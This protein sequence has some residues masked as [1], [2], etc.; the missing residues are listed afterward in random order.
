M[1]RVLRS[2]YFSV[3]SLYYHEASGVAARRI[4]DVLEQT[5]ETTLDANAARG[6]LRMAPQVSSTCFTGIKKLPPHHELHRDQGVCRVRPRA[7]APPRVDDPLEGLR[8][9][10]AVCVSRYDHCALALSGGL[11]SALVLALLLDL[12][13][14][15]LSVYTLATQLPG[16]CELKTTQAVADFFGVDLNVVQ[17]GADELIDALPET[18]RAVEAPLYNLHPVSKLILAR[19]MAAD[20][21]D[22]M[23][24]GDGA[25][26]VFAGTAAGDYLPIVGAV[27]RGQP[28]AY[29]S[30]FFDESVIACGLLHQDPGKTR[31]RR[32]ARGWAPG[33]LIDRK[34]TPRIAPWLDVSRHWDQARIE[35]IARALGVALKADTPERKTLWTTLGLLAGQFKAH[36]ACAP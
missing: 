5:A 33:F 23:I 9:A 4:V 30:P 35:C 28:M 27:M 1:N 19:A 21:V 8:T 18:I 7:L 6:Y 15:R 17:A 29:C 34:K 2:D 31:L 13:P 16:Y 32:A 3:D 26:Q 12:A 24:T 10:L 14:R 11:D 25:D 36:L 20:G 22:C